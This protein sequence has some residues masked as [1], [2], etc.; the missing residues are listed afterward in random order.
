MIDWKSFPKPIIALAPMADMSDLPFCLI[1]KSHG[2][3]LMFR[4]MVSSEAVVRLNPKTLKMAEFDER[5]R[6]LVQQIFGSD[7]ATMA[8]AARIIEEKFHPDAI[9]INMGC[10]VYNIVSNFNGAFL[11]KE[12]ARATAI[13]KA[14]KSAVTIPISVK[15]RLGWKDDRDCLEFVKILEDAGADLISVHGRTKEQGYSGKSNWDRIGEAR[16]QVPNVPFLVNGDIVTV[17]DAR[18]ALAKSGADGV[19]IGRGALGNPWIFRDIM[20]GVGANPCVRPPF[21]FDARGGQTQGSAPT[22]TDRASAVLA[23]AQ[24]QVEHYGERGLIKLRKHL[25]WY[26]KNM[27]GWKDLRSQLVR[28]STLDELKLVLELARV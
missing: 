25:P 12:P 16:R 27:S 17:E 13:I 3:P 10:P 28:I 18:Q 24:L 5:E 7:P 19:L 21:G 15:T 11:I 20:D 2:A 26:F 6:P 23:H 8:E 22:M 14:M 9:D 4:E 1:C